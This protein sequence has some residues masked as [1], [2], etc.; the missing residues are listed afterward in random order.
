MIK[1][2][3]HTSGFSLIEIAIVIFILSILLTSA[4]ISVSS[5]KKTTNYSQARKQLSQIEQALYGYAAANN[6]LPCPAIPGNGGLSNQPNQASNC[7]NSLS[8]EGFIGF[9]PSTSLG[10]QG[11]VNCD[12]LLLDPWGRPYR[13]SVSNTDV[14]DGFADFVVFN[15]IRNE[16]MSQVQANIEICR[17]LTTGCVLGTPPAAN[18]VS[19]SAVAVIFSM[20]E[21][22]E[23]SPREDENAGQASITGSPN[24]GSKTYPLSSNR[25]YYSADIKEVAGAEFDD[26]LTWISPNI[27]FSKMLDS[28]ALP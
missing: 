2:R 19:N 8:I 14:S 7:A 3:V 26:I 27:L 17:N 28:N 22:R 21:P 13:Y 23:N 1:T 12:G 20:G 6:R 15:G 18:F 24:C 9:I 11:R 25:L 5:L 4:V 16:G 10:I